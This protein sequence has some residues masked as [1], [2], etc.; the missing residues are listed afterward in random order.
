MNSGL[1]KD[2]SEDHA[3]DLGRK[4]HRSQRLR[5]P[6][7]LSGLRVGPGIGRLLRIHVHRYGVYISFCAF[8]V[9]VPVLVSGT[10][11]FGLLVMNCDDQA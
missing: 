5:Y 1:G 3:H 8:L 9:L 2:S 6:A 11:A 4:S 10:L 7:D